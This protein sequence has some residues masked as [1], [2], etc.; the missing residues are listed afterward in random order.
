[1]AAGLW[2]APDHKTIA[3]FRKDNG[4]A[5][6]KVCA[7]FVELCRKMGLLAKASV[8]IDG[9]KFKAINNRDKNFTKAKV[10]RRR[11]QLEQSVA[12]YLAQLDT[13]DRQEQLETIELK[14][15]R[16]KEK[17]TKLKSEMVKLEAIEK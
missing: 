14:R 5:I 7:Q 12:R 3:D 17:L 15:T 9:S 11:T 10:E 13:A 16:L 8:A 4:P 2:L 1:M 6:K